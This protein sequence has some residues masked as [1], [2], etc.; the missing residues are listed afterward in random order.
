MGAIVSY[1]TYQS[2]KFSDVKALI[3]VPS[4]LS[5]TGRLMVAEPWGLFLSKI[6][7]D[8]QGKQFG[9]LS[10]LVIRYQLIFTYLQYSLVL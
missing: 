5:W 7:F 9:S 6:T 4:P 1:A 2:V 10:Y 3:D 8:P